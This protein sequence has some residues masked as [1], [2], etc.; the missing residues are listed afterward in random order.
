VKHPLR[1]RSKSTE[2]RSHR[3]RDELV[4]LRRHTIASP[5][6]CT[7]AQWDELSPGRNREHTGETDDTS[8]VKRV[9]ADESY[10]WEHGRTTTTLVDY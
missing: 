8:I 2:T 1:G 5:V 7:L 6:I 4:G 9:F 3:S 10:G